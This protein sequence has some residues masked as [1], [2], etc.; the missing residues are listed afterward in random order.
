MDTGTGQGVLHAVFVWLARPH[1]SKQRLRKN[2]ILGA[3][4]MRAEQG[5]GTAE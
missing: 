3:Y 4:V 2:S 1:I 5:G